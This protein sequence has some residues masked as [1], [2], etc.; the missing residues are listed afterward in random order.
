MNVSNRKQISCMI[1][2]WCGRRAAPR[3]GPGPGRF[4]RQRNGR[5]VRRRLLLLHL[6]PLRHRLRLLLRRLLHWAPGYACICLSLHESENQS[7]EREL[8]F[9]FSG[10]LALVPVTMHATGITGLSAQGRQ[11]VAEDAALA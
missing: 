2:V 4:M 8:R 11:A 5:D 3:A 10:T 1:I 7:S 6:R 9:Q